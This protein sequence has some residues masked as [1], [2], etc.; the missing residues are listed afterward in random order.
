MI[1]EKKAIQRYKENL[2]FFTQDVRVEFID[3]YV[4]GEYRLRIEKIIEP[5]LGKKVDVKA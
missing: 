5:W 2:Y 3:E 4:E 1:I